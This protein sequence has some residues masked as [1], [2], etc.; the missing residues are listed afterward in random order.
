VGAELKKFMM[1]KSNSYK[2][3]NGKLLAVCGSDDYPGAAYL[4]C[5]SAIA[6]MRTGVDLVTVAVPENVGWV[7]NSLNPDI[8]TVKLKGSYLNLSHEKE[9]T[10]LA[11]ASDVILLGPGIGTRVDTLKLVKRLVKIKKAKVIDA[12]AI[13]AITFNEVENAILTPHKGELDILLSNSGLRMNEY[14]DLKNYLGNNVVIVK[15]EEDVIIS[16]EEMRVNKTGNP[17]MTS[18]GTGDVLCGLCAGL[19]TQ[20]FTLIDSAFNS[21]KIMGKTGDKLKEKFG[22][23]FIASDFLSEIAKEVKRLN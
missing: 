5:G 20:G 18:G 13:K 9:I 19:L 12:D 21:A 16:S 6:A 15:G 1:R 2:G 10:E 11:E 14:S 22:Y 3:E 8:I 23:G 7:I 17:G 4:A